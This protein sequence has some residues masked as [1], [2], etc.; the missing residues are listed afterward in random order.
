VNRLKT[1]LNPPSNK[2][3]AF[4]DN[5]MKTWKPIYV[6]SSKEPKICDNI[7]KKKKLTHSQVSCWSQVGTKL[8]KLQNWGKLE[9][10]SQLSSLK[11][12]E[13]PAEAPGL[14]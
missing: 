13:E 1:K 12:V 3:L 14:D 7:A 11:G 6:Y 4:N 10:R 8:F 2:T 9:A 5:Y